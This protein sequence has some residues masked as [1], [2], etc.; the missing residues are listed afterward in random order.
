MTYWIVLKRHLGRWQLHSGHVDK[1]SALEETALRKSPGYKVARCRDASSSSILAV[2]GKWNST[3]YS[4]RFDTLDPQE[5]EAYYRD[6]ATPT[7]HRSNWAKPKSVVLLRRYEDGTC[8]CDG[9]DV[10]SE[11]LSKEQRS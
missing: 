8:T 6:Y 7:C 9:L 2:V 4:K 5:L 3:K 10:T 11:V 1:A